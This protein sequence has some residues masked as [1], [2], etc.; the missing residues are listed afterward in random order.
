MFFKWGKKKQAGINIH[1]NEK[2][3]YEKYQEVS[4]PFEY[5]HPLGSTHTPW[6]C[7]PGPNVPGAVTC[8]PSVLRCAVWAADK[9]WRDLTDLSPG[10]NVVGLKAKIKMWRSYTER[11][12]YRLSNLLDFFSELPILNQLRQISSHKDPRSV[13]IR[14]L[15]LGKKIRPRKPFCLH[16]SRWW[17]KVV[18]AFP[19]MVYLVSSSICAPN[20]QG[21]EIP[22]WALPP[23]RGLGR[24]N[25]SWLP[26]LLF[27]SYKI[28][29]AIL[30]QPS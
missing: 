12:L 26:A 28:Q 17:L 21:L 20:K 8:V 13:R 30:P 1:A 15:L 14:Q 5:H 27:M 19:W 6:W 9:R 3:L 4:K 11:R 24:S 22:A 23:Y 7:T 25:P 16:R 29:P 10:K 2:S 18:Q